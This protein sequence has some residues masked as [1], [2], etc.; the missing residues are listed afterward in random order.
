MRSK[1]LFTLGRL[2][3]PM[4]EK[5][6]KQ[7]SKFKSVLQIELLSLLQY[8]IS[9]YKLVFLSLNKGEKVYK[10]H[11]PSMVVHRWE[12]MPVKRLF[13]TLLKKVLKP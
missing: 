8:K 5:E 2:I 13:G 10:V 9:Y 1:L 4:N 6:L 7:A 11:T 3:S 12:G